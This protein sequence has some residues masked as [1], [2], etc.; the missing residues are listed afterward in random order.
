MKKTGPQHILGE[1]DVAASNALTAAGQQMHRRIGDEPPLS[2]NSERGP[3]TRHRLSIPTTKLRPLRPIALNYAASGIAVFPGAPWDG[4]CELCRA[5]PCKKGR[6]P[7]TENGLKDTTTDEEVIARWWRR[8]AAAN[9]GWAMAR[10]L[11][12]L[13]LGGEAGL[14]ARAEIEAAAELL[15][16][17]NRSRTGSGEHRCFTVPPGSV[18]N[19]SLGL[20][21]RTQGGCL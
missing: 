15:P 16:D 10:G 21:V 1:S 20:C 11:M 17:T 3:H 6:H 4:D 2:A 18:K 19:D 9:I 8:W 12:A 5:N 13:D 14:N 7:L